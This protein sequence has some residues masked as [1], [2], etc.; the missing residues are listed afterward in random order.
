MGGGIHLGER[1]I[2]LARFDETQERYSPD[3][4]LTRRERVA[5]AV[6]FRDRYGISGKAALDMVG[7]VQAK[8][9]Q[10]LDARVE[11]A[12]GSPWREGGNERTWEEW[13]Q[14]VELGPASLS[15]PRSDL[16]EDELRGI[17]RGHSPARTRAN[18]YR[19]GHA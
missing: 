10:L 14:A 8:Q 11:A 2:D 5:L 4:R 12:G 7:D 13:R 6:T 17:V 3:N 9:Q 15:K 18:Q 19:R 1:M 16:T